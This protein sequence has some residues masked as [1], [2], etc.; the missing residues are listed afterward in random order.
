MIVL[1]LI[2]VYIDDYE[3]FQTDDTRDLEMIVRDLEYLVRHPIDLNTAGPE[4]LTAIPYLTVSDCL[5][6]V[7]YRTENGPYR[8]VADLNNIP[9]IDTMLIERIMP[10]VTIGVKSLVFEKFTMRLRGMTDIPSEQ[11]AHEYYTRSELYLKDYHV[12]FLTEKD[13]FEDNFLDYYAGGIFYKEGARSFILGKY[14]LDFGSGVMLSPLGSFLQTVDFRVLTKERGVVPYTS[15]SENSGF[16][17]AALSDTNVIGY[18]VFYSNQDLDGTVDTAGYATSFYQSGDHVDSLTLAKKD[19]INEE[20]I[21]YNVFYRQPQWEIA[22]RT[23]WGA[24]TPGFVSSDSFVDFYGT[25]FWVTGVGLKYYNELMVLFMECARSFENRVGGVFGLS[26][27][28]SIVDINLAGKYFPAGFHSPKGVE[29]RDDYVG[30]Q[31]ALD[32][33]LPIANVGFL[34]TL[35]D[36]TDEDPARYGVQV[37]ADRTLGIVDAKLQLRWRFTDDE[38]Q[39]SGSRIFVR[40]RPFRVFFFDVRL[41]DKYVYVEDGLERGLFGA[42]E[43]G[44]DF[45]RCDIRVR[46]GHFDTDSYASRIYAYEIDLPGIVN[47]RMLYYAG[48]YGF[49]YLSVKP[50]DG[51]KFSIKYSLLDREET[52]EK[53]VGAQLDISL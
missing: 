27:Y 49:V 22:N 23:Y 9:G 3:L 1:F 52:T 25:G 15:V 53:H 45:R 24:Y 32:G 26:G 13:P 31:F 37:S 47:N 48:N 33:H 18:T 40:I 34:F 6:I 11:T 2:A 28:Y 42:L 36:G 20:L 21:G 17:G 29:A 43:C 35:D 4:E 5:R 12:Y 38:S 50:V 41:E 39:R 44:L 10:F 14:N 46:L 16:F 8:S 51:M 7:E 19:R 30:G